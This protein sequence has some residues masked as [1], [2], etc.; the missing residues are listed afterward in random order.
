MK[1]DKVNKKFVKYA[2]SSNGRDYKDIEEAFLAGENPLV[3]QAD[4]IRAA[5]RIAIAGDTVPQ[6]II[7]EALSLEYLVIAAQRLVQSGADIS[8]LENKLPDS[9]KTKLKE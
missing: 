5:L 9:T 8:A 1:K 4:G 7:D 6:I 2:C 3:M